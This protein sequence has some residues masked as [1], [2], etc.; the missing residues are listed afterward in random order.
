MVIPYNIM[1]VYSEWM[2]GFKL[3]VT[4]SNSNTQNWVTVAWLQ[5]CNLLLQQLISL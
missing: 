4:A 1:Y 3:P 2:S 5:K